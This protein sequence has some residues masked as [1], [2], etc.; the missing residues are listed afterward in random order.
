MTRAMALELAP[1]TSAVVNAIAPGLTDTAQPRYGSSEAELA[2]TARAIP[3]GRMAQPEEV[4]RAAV[5]LRLRRRRL[6]DRADLARQR[7][8]VLGVAFRPVRVIERPPLPAF[9]QRRGTR[10]PQ[11]GVVN[12][13]GHQRD[14]VGRSRHSGM[15]LS[16]PVLRCRNTGRAVDFF[17]RCCSVSGSQQNSSLRNDD[18]FRIFH[19][20]SA[21]EVLPVADDRDL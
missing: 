7:R 16:G 8:F 20:F 15:P 12:K 11:V 14:T 10:A 13:S 21:P 4:A 2:E 6:R 18:V 19:K 3:L 9:R 1:S 5:F 17:G